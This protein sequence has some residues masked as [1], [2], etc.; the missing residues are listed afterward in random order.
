MAALTD[1]E[2]KSVL[3]I[4]F[5]CLALTACGGEDGADGATGP[6]G[7]QGADG[8]TGPAGPAGPKGDPGDPASLT[9]PGAFRL[10]VLHNNDGESDLLDAGSG[11]LS[12]YGG[13]HRFKAVVDAAKMRATMETD[14]AI[15]VSSGDN[16]LAGPEFQASLEAGTFYDATALEA[17]GYDA[18]CLGNHDF[19]FGPDVLA[20]FIGQFTQ[21]Q[22]LSA[23]LDFSAEASLQ[24]HVDSGRIAKA[25]TVTVGGQEVGIVGATTPNLRSI[26][27]PRGVVVGAVAAAVQ[28][29]VDALTAAGVNKIVLIS[30]LQSLNEDLALAPLLTDVDI[31]VAGGG[32]ELLARPTNPLIP[33]ATESGVYPTLVRTADGHTA[34]VITSEGGYRYLGRLVLDFDAAGQVVN[35]DVTSSGPIRVSGDPDDADAVTGDAALVTSVLEPVRNYVG[36]LDGN[37]IATSEVPLDG[38]RANIRG[39][40]T[41]LGDLIADAFLWQANVLAAD[42]AV[43]APQVA[44]A[45]GGGIRNASVLP[46]GDITELDTFDVLP[47]SNFLTVV[48]DV[49]AGQFVQILENAVSRVE[50]GSGRFAQVAG[51]RFTYDPMGTAQVV[52]DDGTVEVAGTRVVNVD[53][54]D[55]M[56]T[57]TALVAN[58]VLVD[59]TA[60]VDVA[61]VDF[62]ARGG[63][64][65]PFRGAQRTELNNLGVSYQQALF[66]YISAPSAEGGLEGT[67]TAADYP[68]AGLGRI[69]SL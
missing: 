35:V 41:N 50:S 19:D 67:I 65:Y 51:V 31:M 68:E 45:N 10:T 30:H 11:D 34:Y 24:A 47:F 52:A 22:Y 8:A 58:G 6:Q 23:N 61:I 21:V 56:G 9:R 53:L 25:V 27:S 43:H 39:Q 63:D 42:F 69:T 7:P 18:I 59:P 40:E 4:L 33:G 60:T 36:A 3:T 16:F 13:V 48:E 37:V 28:A 2:L 29:E 64:Q 14:G 54:V 49:P 55:A 26:S 44:L 20:S 66:G 15:F 46:A 5:G 17:L 1:L 12:N 57:A 32:D 62:L 38:L